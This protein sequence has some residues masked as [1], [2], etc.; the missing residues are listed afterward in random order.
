MP[1]GVTPLSAG[2]LS[3]LFKTLTIRSSS[4]SCSIVVTLHYHITLPVLF[5]NMYIRLKTVDV[6]APHRHG[7]MMATT[8]LYL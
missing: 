4:P 5:S 1:N 6:T 7:E 8:W 3:V 2:T